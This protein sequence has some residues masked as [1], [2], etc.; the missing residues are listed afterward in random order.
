L[1]TYD[2]AYWQER[3][4]QESTPW[5]MG[6]PS[7]PLIEYLKD[8]DRQTKILIPGAGHAYEAQ[9]LVKQGFKDI[10]VI[11]LSEKAIHNAQARFDSSNQ[12]NWLIGDFFALE[13]SFDLIVEQT[14]FCALDPSLRADYARQM[15]NLL[16]P[17]GRLMGLL[18][19]FP[20]S[21]QGPPFGGDREEYQ[22]LFGQ[23][24]SI[25]HLE[26][27]YNSVKPRAGRE[28]FLELIA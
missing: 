8:C 21:E 25:K 4:L 18:F 13:G 1:S 24:F 14:F 3:Y 5:D 26:P 22:E 11:D 20:L 7:P 23:S 15:K 28:F 16:R 17:E 6:R 2:A 10:T 19:D 27:C 12:V 9:W